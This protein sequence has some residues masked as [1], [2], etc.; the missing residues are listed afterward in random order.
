MSGPNRLPA[1]I[2]L[3]IDRK[4]RIT[5]TFEKKAYQ[6]YA[7][8]TIASAL[9]ANGQWLLSRS[10]K[11]HRPRGI[12]TMAGQDANTLVQL[13]GEPSVLADRE[14]IHSDLAVKAQ[15]YMGSLESD[16]LAILG[17]FSRFLPVGFY[18]KSFFKPRG[19]WE[20]WAPHLRKVAG[21]GHIDV[22]TRARD[23]DKQYLFCDVAVI[24][25]GPA[26][27]EAAL[28]AASAGADVILVDENAVLGGALAYS[29]IDTKGLLATEIREQLVRQI[30][31]EPNIRVMTLAVC[32]AWFADNWLPVIQGN[33]M[34]KTRARECIVCAGSLDQPALFHGNDWPGIMMGSA[35]QRLIKWYGVKPGLRAVVLTGNNDGYAVALDLLDAGV[36]VSAVVEMRELA[37][38]IEMT[39]SLRK[40][41]VAIIPQH[42]IY[43]ASPD[44]KKRH[45]Q[46]VELR[47]ITGRG[48]VASGGERI[49]CDLVCMSAGDM[50]TYQLPCMAGAK[51]DY[52]D[53]TA[54]FSISGLPQ[55]LQIAG[56][57][58]GTRHLDAA[59]AQGKM[60][61]WKAANALQLD[62]GCAPAVCIEEGRE[63]E[64]NYPWPIFPHPKAKEFV[65]FDEDLQIKDIENACIEGYDHV[66]LSKRYSTVGMGPS[67]GRHSALTT[68]RLVADATGSSVAEV[69]VTT[70]RPPFAPEKLGHCAG[71]SFFPSRHSG[72]H[73][74]HIELGAQ[75]MLAGTWL[76]PAYYG[77][78]G[79]RDLCMQAEAKNVRQN[80]GLVDVSTLGGIEIRGPDSAEM[81]NRI[82][83]WGFAKQPVE[84]ARYAV[85]C[86]EQGVV[87]DDGVACRFDKNHYY[88]TAST[89]GVDH[90]YQNMLRWNSQ[91]RLDVD[92]ANVTAAWAAVNI[93]GPNAR[94]VLTDVCDDV[95]LT[96][97]EFPYMG[98]REGMVAG[99]TSRLIRVGFVGELGYEVHVPAHCAEALWDA[100]MQAGQPYGIKPFGIE[101]QRLLRME[102]GHL[103]IGQDTDAMTHPAEVGLEWAISQKKAFFIGARSIREIE[104]RPLTRKLAGFIISESESAK[105]EESHLVIRD[106]QISGRVT[107]CY[108]SPTVGQT[109]GLAYVAPDQA[110]IGTT[111]Q[112]R[113]DAAL[114]NAQIVTLPFYDPNNQRQEM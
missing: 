19:A 82:Y 84:R 44:K 45:L 28:S 5:F 111:I 53:L 97:E 69:G 60:A 67:Q 25:G 29:R 64:I 32:N 56:S 40:R 8:D 34:Y 58:N 90:V 99:I 113:V 17:Y 68:A 63:E 78:K 70:A 91:W 87:I 24:G 110:K 81:I 41:N 27:M 6:G 10:F 46:A 50:P 47:R 37:P 3:L 106:G 93:A 96:A 52:D 85:S 80:V 62:V 114:V 11:Y 107:S 33:R 7:G 66:Q 36:V 92:I 101:A 89:G 1:P 102:K 112:I 42:T 59:R 72:I 21:L 35:A 94:A 86:N 65:D 100:L 57:I 108:V 13:P 16:R 20:K 22:N 18:Y 61:G 95:S 14:R 12:L 83:T 31:A 49:E 104:K 39:A 4:Q 73:H 103:I 2:G 54:R 88:V 55:N 109:I 9:A 105:P 74:R 98:V 23:Y 76:R 75:F 15:N 51:L 30:A 26:G 38:Q 43:A 79:S 71:R 77:A 48:Q